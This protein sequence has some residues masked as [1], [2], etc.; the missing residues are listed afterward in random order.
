MFRLSVLCLLVALAMRTTDL[1]AFS[2]DSY[3]MKSV[4]AEGRWVKVSVK[5]DGIHFIPASALKAMGF[6]DPTQVGVYGYG[7]RRLPE[8][9]DASGYVDDLPRIQSIN[10]PAGIYFFAVGVAERTEDANGAAVM[11]C[12]TF[13]SDGFYFLSDCVALP[14]RS[15]EKSGQ[16]GAADPSDSFVE[17]VQHETDL[18]SPGNTGHYMVGEDM[19]FTP[20]RRFTFSL[21]GAVPGGMV[22]IGA[23]LCTDLTSS[24]AWSI[25]A[26]DVSVTVPAE[27]TPAG[28]EYHGVATEGW[29]KDF[30]H[31]GSG[32]LNVSVTLSGAPGNAR[33]AWLDWVAV[34]YDRKISLA[35]SPAIVFTTGAKE[36]A[37]SGA[38]S[39][40]IIWDV[41][42]PLE[43][44]EM[45]MLLSGDTATFTASADGRRT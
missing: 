40:T 11:K 15:I 6:S 36:V 2:P 19:R 39:Q 24:S 35:N 37:L 7:G 29:T 4:L 42:D 25:E 23:S 9:L 31:D 41:T 12:N 20:S 13:S 28:S 34:N 1:M 33:G 43:I 5:D 14:Q 16:P 32:S 10:D 38:T 45:P 18:V 3:A 26:G 27:A 44:K 21:P 30:A 22:R 17:C 8:V